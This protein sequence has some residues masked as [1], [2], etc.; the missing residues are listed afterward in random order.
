MKLSGSLTNENLE[1]VKGAVE[2]AKR[3]VVRVHDEQGS[4][5]RVLFDLSDFTGTY[6]VGP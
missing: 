5:V 1:E 3:E 6:N 2:E 4:K